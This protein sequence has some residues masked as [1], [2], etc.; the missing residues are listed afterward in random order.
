MRSSSYQ[1]FDK[2]ITSSDIC[3][4]RHGLNDDC[5]LNIFKYLRVQDFIQ[6][7]KLDTYFHNLIATEFIAKKVIDLGV[8]DNRMSD[9]QFV[10]FES[11]PRFG[12]FLK[13]FVIRGYDFNLFLDAIVKYCEPARFTD[14]KLEFNYSF[15]GVNPINRSIPFF[16][17][18]LSLSDVNSNG[19]YQQ[20]LTTLCR[21]GTSLEI[22][23]LHKVD[24][25][26]GWLQNMQN[27]SELQILSPDIVSLDDLTNCY[28]ANPNLITFRYEGH[29]NISKVYDTLSKCCPRLKTFSDCHI[30]S[31]LFF[32][33]SV[34]DRYTFLSSLTQLVNVTLTSYSETGYELSNILKIPVL[35]NIS[36]LDVFSNY[37]RLM[38]KIDDM[39]EEVMRTSLMEHENMKSNESSINRF[40]YE[41]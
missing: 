7:C 11:F 22:L 1:S 20:F 21:H 10:T 2:P 30:S 8:M 14:V 32:E 17:N 9:D 40:M 33:A 34:K 27:L 39:N 24:I 15:P 37:Q 31:N 26:G 35:A 41:S 29:E 13:N 28:R 12:K 4:L 5:L 18:L 23:Q 6:L 16:S 38:A 19:L 36:K 25:V 3:R